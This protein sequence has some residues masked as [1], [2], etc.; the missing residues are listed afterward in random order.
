[1]LDLL[2]G[3]VVAVC[4]Q[5]VHYGHEQLSAF[6]MYLVGLVLPGIFAAWIVNTLKLSPCWPS[7][8]VCGVS[9]GRRTIL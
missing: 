5:A 4:A 1:M 9:G 2:I 8:H 7:F 3:V 6:R